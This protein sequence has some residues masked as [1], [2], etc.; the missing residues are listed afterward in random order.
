MPPLVR[1]QPERALRSVP[2][3]PSS[4]SR[5]PEPSDAEVLAGYGAS[6]PIATAEFLRRF[7][8]RVYGLAVT[9]LGDA[10]AAEDVAQEALLR[11]WRN[12]D[13]FDAG[14]GRVAPW[15]LT[16][17]R[18]L[19]ID[20]VRVRRP[21]AFDPGDLL[22]M[23]L[24]GAERAPDDA[25]VVDDDIDRLRDALATLPDDQARAVVLAGVWGLTAREISERE[26]IP[27]GTAK[28]RIRIALRRLRVALADTRID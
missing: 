16:I 4:S 14:R 24:A 25:A 20:A 13:V 9:I 11:A 15:L 21:V 17:T 26:S 2:K 7:Q 22:G 12:A 1:T 3:P 19:A 5:D 6:D 10:R 27:L 18:N 28:T 8:R 23:S